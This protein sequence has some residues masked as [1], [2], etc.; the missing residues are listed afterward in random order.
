MICQVTPS[1]LSNADH[2]PI[3]AE[4]TMPKLTGLKLQYYGFPPPMDSMGIH[5]GQG[6]RRGKAV[7]LGS[8]VQL[9]WVLIWTRTI[10]EAASLS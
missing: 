5:R 8:P 3:A 7:S 2:L 6:F 4:G 1:P 10:S 9:W